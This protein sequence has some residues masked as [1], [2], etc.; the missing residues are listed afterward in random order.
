M[1]KR[2]NLSEA[3]ALYIECQLHNDCS[4]C[5]YSSING[6]TDHCKMFGKNVNP[7]K[8]APHHFKTALEYWKEY[9]KQIITNRLDKI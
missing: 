4:Q 9:N 5:E 8:F 3:L 7:S 1:N 2:I 6:G